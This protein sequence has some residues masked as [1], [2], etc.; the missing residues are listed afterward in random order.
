MVG[1]NGMGSGFK[2][3]IHRPGVIQGCFGLSKE[4]WMT[5][6]LDMTQILDNVTAVFRNESLYT[7]FPRLSVFP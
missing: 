1:F 3:A 6:I 2:G 4:P 5:P 7:L